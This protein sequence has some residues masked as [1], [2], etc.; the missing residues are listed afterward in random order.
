MSDNLN[1][2]L[3]PTEI[4]VVISGE[5]YLL[6]EASEAVAANYTNA[7]LRGARMDRQGKMA[8]LPSDLGGLQAILVSDCLFHATSEGEPGSPVPLADV[9]RWPSRVVKPLFEKAKKI[10]EI[11]EEETLES[12]TKQLKEIVEKI[13]NLQEEN[14]TKNELANTTDG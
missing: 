3:T 9:Q 8:T 2:D 11:G 13:K 14:P 5:K 12:L 1:F 7:S 10:S 6:C 4:N